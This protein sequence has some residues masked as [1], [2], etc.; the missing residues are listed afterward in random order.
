MSNVTVRSTQ[1][2]LVAKRDLLLKFYSL[3]YK[4]MGQHLDPGL[5]KQTFDHLHQWHVEAEIEIIKNGT[6]F[7]IVNTLTRPD[8]ADKDQ[9]KLWDFYQRVFVPMLQNYQNLDAETFFKGFE[10]VKKEALRIK[11]KNQIAISDKSG[12]DAELSRVMNR[13]KALPD[14]KEPKPAAPSARPMSEKE[15][16]DDVLDVTPISSF[17]MKVHAKYSKPLKKR[18]VLYA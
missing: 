15:I 7:E 5:L 9:E 1:Q 17:F 2:A 4:A 13:M 14:G 3:L 10:D 8:V 6:L 11:R 16:G 18:N 12:T